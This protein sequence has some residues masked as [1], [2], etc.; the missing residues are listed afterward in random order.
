MSDNK[1]YVVSFADGVGNYIKAML[2]LELSLKQVGF[3][4]YVEIFKGINDYAHISSP[5]H[6]GSLDAIP[7][8]FKA[9][10][11]QKS[12]DEGARFI[13]WCDSV[14]YATK[15]IEPIFKHIE[16]HGY[17]FFDNIGFSIGDY[18]SDACLEKWGMTRQEAFESKMIAACVMGFDIENQQAKEFLN[19]YI[20]AA[21]DG[22]SYYGSWTNEN[23]QASNDMRVK[24]HRHDQS[25]ASIIIKQMGLKIT[26]SQSTYF[27]YAEHKGKVLI[28]DTVCLWSEGI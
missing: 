15:S 28:N 1:K 17:L 21:S 24:G 16:E 4:S 3:E 13:L 19:K 11:I 9:Y 14:V 6:K 18:T 7:Y 10:S 25:V 23:L 8:A 20:A 22:I 27:A 12:I 5:F 2:R 26:N